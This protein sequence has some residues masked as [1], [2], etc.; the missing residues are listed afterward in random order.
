MTT[1][2]AVAPVADAPPTAGR[3]RIRWGQVAVGIALPL[4]LVV[5]W[6]VSASIIEPREWILP[7]PATIARTGWE[8]RD[9]LWYHAQ[10]TILITVL[11]FAL[12]AVVG[13]AVA[14][15]IARSRIAGRLLYPW[16]IVSQ[17]IP[18]VALAPLL[19]L[20]MPELGAMIALAALW[21][22][23]PVIVAG[24]DGLRGTDPE[25][26]RAV[27][28]LGASPGWTWWHVRA[29]GA[30]PRLFT[31]LRL[32]AVFSVTGAVVGEMVASSR[33]LGALTRLS[34]AQFE[35]PVTFAAVV[36][37]ALIGIAMFALVAL[38]EWLSLPYLRRGTRPGINPPTTE[39]SP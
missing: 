29:P 11:G 31:G 21:S 8:V 2:P 3:R 7:S 27:R 6:Q 16:V 34:A 13:S 22:V 20:W 1:V 24:V 32:A 36:V 12:A 35:T 10:W 39:V 28:A 18:L 30:L 38:T 5:I 9:R 19:M 25:L 37:L 14:A 15:L 33:G 23:F 17:T 4:L 26:M